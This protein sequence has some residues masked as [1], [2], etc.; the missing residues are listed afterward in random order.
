M[1]APPRANDTTGIADLVRQLVGTI[2]WTEL[3]WTDLFVELR[4]L[5]R[6]SVPGGR[7]AEGHVD[8]LRILQQAG[9]APHPGALYGVW[10]SRSR[11]AAVTARSADGTDGPLLLSGTMPF[12]SGCGVI[13]RSLV[14]VVTE[15]EPARNLLVDAAVDRWKYDQESWCS[16]AMSVSRSFTLQLDAEPVPADAVVGEPGFYLER[17]A[18]LPGGIGVAAVWTGGAQAVLDVLVGWLSAGTLDQAQSLRIG[19]IALEIDTCCALLDRAAAVLDGPAE[20]IPDET[21]ALCTY[22]RAGIGAAVRRALQTARDC[23]GPAGAAHVPQLSGAIA[24]LDLYVR[25][26]HADRDLFALSRRTVPE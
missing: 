9:R 19:G 8:A 22:T 6:R 13:D 20:L 2:D 1:I 14:T 26:Q 3:S 12:A 23:A 15:T 25:Q 11:G 17:P 5:G 16:D 10:A 21:A 4:K 7:L 24:D 18:F